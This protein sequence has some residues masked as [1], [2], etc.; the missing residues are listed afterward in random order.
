MIDLLI[1]ALLIV[2]AFLA[3]S[4]A[5]I[6]PPTSLTLV[7]TACGILL[8]WRFQKAQTR[9]AERKLFLD[10]MPRRAEWYDRVK[11]ALEGRA[12]ERAK[13]VDAIV[14]GQAPKSPEC[15]VRLWQ[16]ETEA[17]WLF[18]SEMVALMARVIQADD[19]LNEKQLEARFGDRSAALAVSEWATA[20]SQSQGAVQDYLA[21]FLYVGDIGKPKRSP[22]QFA[23]VKRRG[24][25]GVL[26]SKIARR[27]RGSGGQPSA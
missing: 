22:I 19:K 12:K 1:V 23:K 10:L 8:L 21:S 25:L 24:P 9:L 13:Q 4:A 16:L 2:V 18:G 14:N 26:G 6:F 27:I 15:L 3:T 11:I 17:G 7:V 20:L 5:V